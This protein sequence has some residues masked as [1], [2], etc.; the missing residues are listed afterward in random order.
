MAEH[1]RPAIPFTDAPRGTCR[2]CGEAIVHE[3]GPKAGDVNFRRRW[4]PACIDAYD[5]TDPR[6]LRRSVR[7]RDRGICAGCGLD[8]NA[9]RR[10]LRELRLDW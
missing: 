10:E 1:R 6:E 5:R 3:K 8:T 9:L 2:W 4:H 7:K